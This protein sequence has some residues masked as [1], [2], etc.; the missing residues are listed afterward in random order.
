MQLLP[1]VS[2]L[3]IHKHHTTFK[4]QKI[5]NVKLKITLLCEYKSGITIVDIRL[6]PR[7]PRNRSVEYREEK[8]ADTIGTVLVHW[9]GHF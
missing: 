7:F 8:C 6:R 1:T 3:S 5:N 9:A 4:V 2:F